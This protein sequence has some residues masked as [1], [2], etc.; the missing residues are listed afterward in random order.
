MKKRNLNIKSKLFISYAIFILFLLAVAMV[1]IVAVS[2]TH[3]YT[4]IMYNHPLQVRRNL[5]VFE[6]QVDNMSLSFRELVLTES[7]QEQ[8]LIIN[9]IVLRNEE[10]RQ[11][12]KT[13]KE[14]YLGPAEDMLEVE[15]A[16]LLWQ[17]E[18]DQ[19]MTLI[20]QGN[21][22]AAISKML[23]DGTL[24]TRKHKLTEKIEIVNSFAENKADELLVN[25]ALDKK[26]THIS[27][28]ILGLI[29]ILIVFIT[30]WY[31]HRLINRPLAEL[32]T[33]MRKFGNGNFDARVK[34]IHHDELGFISEKLNEMLEIIEV[35]HDI[36]EKASSI[37]SQI[38]TTELI[39]DFFSKM[40]LSI[41]SHT[42]ADLG[43]VYLSS[44]DQNVFKIAASIGM[45]EKGRA[46][47]NIKNLEGD[48]GRAVASR[49]IERFSLSKQD[50][51]F[52]HAVPYG[53]MFPKE[54]ITVPI[55]DK[56]IPIAI[57]TIASIKGFDDT[58][59]D[60]LENTFPVLTTRTIG[61]L[62]NN[63]I[64]EMRD[65][66]ETK[67]EELKQQQAELQ[68]LAAE[69]E[70]Q[71]SELEI[72]NEKL[73]EV[74]R[75]KTS[76]LSNMSHELRTPLNSVIALSGIL[77]RKLRNQISEE[78][79]SYLEVIER[80]G[81]NLLLM[82][83]D[84]LD[85]SKIE[86][87]R[88]DFDID[89][90]SLSGLI[91]E[92]TE[93]LESLAK[94]KVIELIDNSIAEEIHLVSDE[95]MLRHILQNL[96]G[97]AIK[98]TEKGRVEITA[99]KI[100]GQAVIKVSDTGIGIAEENLK[101]IFEEF[102]Q[103]DGSTT[104]KYGGTGLGLAISKKYTELLGGTLEVESILD[105]GSVFTVTIPM[106]HSDENMKQQ[107]KALKAS[108][109]K[110]PLPEMTRIKSE[111]NDAKIHRLLIVEDSEPAVIQI[112]D[113]L[114]D[115]NYKITVAIDG[116]EA[117]KRIEESIPDAIILDLMMPKKDGFQVLTEVRNM[118]LTSHVPVLVLTAKHI[119]KE[120]L[121]MLKHNYIHQLV[122][123][124]SLS[125]QGLQDAVRDMLFS[126]VNPAEHIEKPIILLVEDNPDN[127]LTVSALLKEKY[128]IVEAEDG[129]S[130]I[131]A[132]EIHMPDLILMDIAL[133][134]MDGVEALKIIRRNPKLAHIPVIA[135]TASAMTTDREIFLAY[136]F[137][138][139]IPKPIIEKQFKRI[140]EEVLYV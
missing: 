119:T 129:E 135:L 130:A 5:A 71:K 94:E 51:R 65:E 56:E 113:A 112:K 93:M 43:A 59:I 126:T 37:I 28:I 128:N 7:P 99:Q 46:S 10:A 114:V 89:R 139:F 84:I 76:F 2:Q 16:F 115:E 30:A 50:E 70:Q 73:S 33:T 90:F 21:T 78:E 34:N 107:I 131:E 49:K 97:N 137:D 80:S 133:Q 13:L 106:Q 53:E 67:N 125:R 54:I 4:E 55:F 91:K 40:L 61:V 100:G 86:A 132:A 103:A 83:N 109:D 45:G 29:A 26:S 72:Q 22:E 3:D 88:I 42:K 116:E 14:L 18:M 124:G 23:Q 77:E 31:I 25:S 58:V 35:K 108:S 44:T 47:F 105:K 127:R 57:I 8:D 140:L 41:L 66:L 122:Q 60:L 17:D 27:I 11:R 95:H 24:S 9:N 117:L 68:L 81:K 120:E 12:L 118:A 62:S 101:H 48:L 52:L 87:G 82:I 15:R 20:S 121:K 36:N 85:I 74:N 64:R 75:L 79:H 102:R 63:E 19:T 110:D 104:R 69:I 96:I 134:G 1:G 6:L 92:L 32:Q 38:L 39:E 138:A 136:G 111:N 123:K 98:F